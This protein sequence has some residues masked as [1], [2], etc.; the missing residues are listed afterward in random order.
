MPPSSRKR[1]AELLAAQGRVKDLEALFHRSEAELAAALSDKRG[2]E[3]DVVELR[4]QLAKVG[5]GR[6]S[7]PPAGGLLRVRGQGAQRPGAL[8]SHMVQ[9]TDCRLVS[10]CVSQAE[11]GH[12]VARQQLE[13]ET[14]M[15]VDLENRRQSLQEELDFRKNVFE[16]VR[17]AGAA[18]HGQG[19][20]G[21]PCRTTAG[22]GARPQPLS[23][24]GVWGS[25]PPLACGRVP[26]VYCC[27]ARV[28]RTLVGFGPHLDGPE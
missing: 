28:R 11:D 10:F 16:E 9:Q 14:L 19:V 17:P 4:A 26:P 25:R 15:R 5:P 7:R 18:L 2:L 24:I 12:A 27:S 21:P 8:R 22:W 13:K 1:E 23:S 6:G 20:P 3:S